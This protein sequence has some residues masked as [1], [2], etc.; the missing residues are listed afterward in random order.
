[1]LGMAAVA[2]AMT[3]NLDTVRA[4]LEIVVMDNREE[5][6][7][8][9]PGEVIGLRERPEARFVELAQPSSQ[10]ATN[11]ECMEWYEKMSSLIE[12]AKNP[13]LHPVNAIPWY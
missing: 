3:Q 8:V 11:D 13:E 5:G 12:N 9:Q 2:H 10:T 1:M 4:F 7:A 6:R